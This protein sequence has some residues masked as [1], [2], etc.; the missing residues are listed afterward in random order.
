MKRLTPFSAAL[1]VALL[2]GSAA[3]YAQH[4]WS[5]IARQCGEAAAEQMHA[6][7]GCAG[8]A[9]AWPS[10]A[11]CAVNAY[12]QGA[13]PVARTKACIDRVWY[14]RLQS[15]TCNACGDPISDVF[16]CVQR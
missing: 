14:Q 9:G 7:T 6:Q 15:Q 11:M 8:C 4:P 13:I 1:T 3:G 5:P 16:V 12:F 10:G 2:C